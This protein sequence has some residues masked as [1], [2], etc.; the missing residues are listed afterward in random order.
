MDDDGYPNDWFMAAKLWA[1][2]N[3]IEAR[4]FF[5]VGVAESRLASDSVG[6]ALLLSEWA[7]F[8]STIGNRD[9]FE[10][11]YSQIFSFEPDV[12]MFRLSYARELWTGFKDRNACI[13]AIAELESLLESER[14]NRVNDLKPLAYEQKVETLR[15]WLN[16][17]SGGPLWP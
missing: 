17:E 13:T 7:Y 16:G 12:P 10:D 8:E 1:K 14:W 5:L 2:G 15:A 11:L 6:P 3:H 4:R 9:A